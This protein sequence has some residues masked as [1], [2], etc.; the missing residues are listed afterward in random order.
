MR[1]RTDS[2][3]VASPRKVFR[4]AALTCL[5]LLVLYFALPVDLSD[6][7]TAILVRAGLSVLALVGIVVVINRQL[8]R[9]IHEPD[10]PLGGL[11]A[12]MVGGL[13]LFALLD[14]AIAIHKTG[15]FAELNTRLDALYFALSTLL[16]VGFGDVH[17][18]GQLARGILCVQMIFN[19]A[20]LATAA[21][22]L[23]SE[24]NR[25]IRDR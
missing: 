14:F 24:I 7:T 15:E 8:L 13:L 2:D 3:Q 1:R 9:Q 6:G 22:M 4:R 16:T 5:G 19:V 23:A 18:E 17:A 11:V 21:S 12:G 20:V 25:R 10:S